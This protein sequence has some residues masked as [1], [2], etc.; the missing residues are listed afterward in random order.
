MAAGSTV[1]GRVPETMNSEGEMFGDMP[2]K[3]YTQ[4]THGEATTS[5]ENIEQYLNNTF[6]SMAEGKEVGV[7]SNC[8]LLEE[9]HDVA[10][11]VGG[12][13]PQP[14]DHMKIGIKNERGPKK[15]QSPSKLLQ[16][17]MSPKLKQK[18][19]TFAPAVDF[20]DLN[21]TFIN[22]TK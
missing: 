13:R 3:L 15:R 6:M 1:E 12:F 20:M 14:T 8:I 22:F 19:G 10:E 16:K 7:Q 2:R 18:E 4:H 5:N 11:Q 9:A 21:K 17:N